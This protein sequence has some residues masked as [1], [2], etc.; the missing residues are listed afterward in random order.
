MW[1]RY[2]ALALCVALLALCSCVGLTRTGGGSEAGSE[3]VLQHI[4]FMVQENRSFDHYFGQLGA[5][6]A[7]N[8]FGA[9]TDV[10]G[11][12]A[13]TSN[14]GYTGG[15][16]NS[17][18]LTTTCL[19]ELSGDWFESHADMNY[20]NPGSTTALMDG[21]ARIAGGYAQFF[22]E[23]NLSGSRAMGY[24]DQDELPYY[25]WMASQY[26][27]SD[28]WFSPVL[29]E[30]IPNRLYLMAA[31]SAGH[32]H[33]PTDQ[34]PCCEQQNLPTIFHLLQAAN[35]TWKIYY[36]DTLPN[37]QPLT[38]I[39]QYWPSFAAQHAANIVSVS[40]YFTDLANNA[41]PAVAFIQAGLG[42]GRD[43]HPGGQ[44]TTGEGGNDIQ[45]GA[46]Y[47]SSLI[48]ALMSSSSWSSSAFILSFDEAGG[49]YDHVPPQSAAQPD[50][51]KPMDLIST[52]ANL[53]PQPDFNQTGFR[54]PMIVVSPFAKSHYVSHTVAD[55]TAILK[56]IEIRFG[57]PSLT[58]RDASEM[59]MSEFFDFTGAPSSNVGVP[60]AQPVAG[61]CN[62]ANV[63]AAP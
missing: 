55:N 5:Y 56:F 35:V 54:I 50:G 2:S 13:N 17:F 26:A 12:P 4:V 18:H 61:L 1:T 29:S 39:N 49:F 32:A 16:I 43:E 44:T 51:I 23:L 10:D 45:K 36:T 62:P 14:P 24:Y 25:Y 48:N 47:V 21:F 60:P 22:G 57:L 9:A 34:Y 19:E 63:P 41:L 53:N 37:G 31:T 58:K 30:S 7:A 38:D 52:D 59:D 33:A 15:S 46:L 8:G 40:Q 6:R 20:E 42:S 27:T 28:R 3:Q 11:L